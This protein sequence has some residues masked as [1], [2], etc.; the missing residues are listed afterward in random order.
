MSRD[1]LNKNSGNIL[2]DSIKKEEEEDVQHINL[3]QRALKNKPNPKITMT[4]H[5][6]LQEA[7]KAGAEKV[8]GSQKNELNMFSEREMRIINLI[9]RGIHEGTSEHESN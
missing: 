1:D 6:D 3:K 7:P 4:A 2:G 5:F 9:S 8:S